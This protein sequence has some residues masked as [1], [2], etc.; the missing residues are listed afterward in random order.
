MVTH[1]HVCIQILETCI[2]LCSVIVQYLVYLPE[3]GKISLKLD[4]STFVVTLGNE[5]PKQ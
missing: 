4:K 3:H 2:V 1:L 5:E